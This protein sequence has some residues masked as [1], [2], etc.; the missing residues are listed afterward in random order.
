MIVVDAFGG[1]FAPEEPIKGAVLAANEYKRNITLVGDEQKILNVFE[2]YSLSKDRIS[3]VHA[4][5]VITCH[6][7]SALSVRRKKKSSLVVAANLVKENENS[8]LVSAGSTGAVLSAGVLV[9]GRMKGVIRPSLG[10]LIPGKKPF[11]LMD[12]GANADCK[13]EYLVQFAIMASVY[14]QNILKVENP[15]VSLAN[16]GSEA[17]KGSILYKET[18]KKLENEKNINFTGNVEAV[19]IM[20]GEH[21]I[22]V[23]DGFTGNMLLKSIE[24]MASLFKGVLKETLYK[25]TKTKLGGALIK[26]DL[27]AAF[28]KFDTKQ[29]GGAPLLGVN[30]GIFKAHGNSKDILIKNTIKQAIDF[31]DNNCLEKIKKNLS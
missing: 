18:Y 21:D 19:N 9:T 25:S 17:E 26:N 23:C 16:I 14:M 1:D 28:K 7:E 12:C 8:V 5:D 3:I 6:D 11:L 20:N 31:S 13:V 22:V 30:G 2:K 27:N 15:K 24:G 29:Y 10:A 4:P